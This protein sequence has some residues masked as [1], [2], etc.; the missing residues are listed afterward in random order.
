M[1]N[2]RALIKVLLAGTAALLITPLKALAAAWP[3]GAFQATSQA[4]AMSD[5]YGAGDAGDS[6]D[7]ILKAP[8]IAENGAVVPI[9]I[10][11]NIAGTD[12]LSLY[13]GGNPNPLVAAFAIPE[14]T[15]A[16]VST[17]IKMAKTSQLV[18][19]ASANGQLHQ[20]SKEVKVTIGGCG[21]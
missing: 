18:A 20:T 6:A 9:T 16:V 15:E 3:S 8:D 12:N 13:V 1:L 5:M 19:V 7:V 21:G 14:G 2:R 10:T 11:S 4:D 17:R